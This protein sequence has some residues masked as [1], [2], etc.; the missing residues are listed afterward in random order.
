MYLHGE[1]SKLDGLGGA[2]CRRAYGVLGRRGVPHV[3]QNGN[4]AVVDDFCN[5]RQYGYD[6]V[7]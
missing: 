7:P 3:R 6:A 4:A 2:G 1:P 5:I